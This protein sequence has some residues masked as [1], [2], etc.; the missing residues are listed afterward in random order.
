M[1][2]PIIFLHIPKT[3]GS[4][5]RALL[6]RQYRGYGQHGVRGLD[7]PELEAAMAALRPALRPATRLIGG[8]VMYGVHRYLPEAVAAQPFTYVTMMREPVDRVISDYHYVLRTPGHDFYDPVATDHYSLEDYVR[9]EITIYTNN[10][11]TRMLAGVGRDVPVGRCTEAMLAQAQRHLNERIPLVGLTERF[12]ESLVLM[13]RAL[14][15]RMPVYRVKNRTKGRP[16]RE[17][18]TPSAH[19]AIE[20]YNALDLALYREATARFETAMAAQGPGFA[21]EVRHLQRLCR[22]YS[23]LERAYVAVRRGVNAVAGR[24]IV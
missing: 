19:A 3:A 13:K 8:H 4:T 21:D 5:L 17:E 20:A 12:D 14:G 10:V 16:K 22:L 6:R 15:W 7:T 23:P 1:P 24:R 11:Q 18:I 9:S 2:R